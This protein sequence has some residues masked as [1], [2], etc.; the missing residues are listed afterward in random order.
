MEQKLADLFSKFAPGKDSLSWDDIQDL[1]YAN[2][3][4][5]AVLHLACM[6]FQLCAQTLACS[7]P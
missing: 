2:M 6:R 5:R 4:V 7:S 3:N 1:V